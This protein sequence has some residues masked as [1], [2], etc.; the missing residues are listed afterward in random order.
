MNNH[1][2]AGTDGF[3]KEAGGSI[4]IRENSEVTITEDSLKTQAIIARIGDQKDQEI[5][6]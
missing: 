4:L 1:S 3:A 2:G 5:F 6:A